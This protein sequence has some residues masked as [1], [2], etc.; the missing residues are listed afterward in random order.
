ML[1]VAGVQ[2]GERRVLTQDGNRVP[3]GMGLGAQVRQMEHV[4]PS[5]SALPTTVK[6]AM[7][8]YL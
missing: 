4:L 6:E 8:R 3:F 1:S 5:A 2:H 7:Q